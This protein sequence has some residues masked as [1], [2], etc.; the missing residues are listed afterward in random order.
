MT[1]GWSRVWSADYLVDAF[2]GLHGLKIHKC[3]KLMWFAA[4]K[5]STVFLRHL[6]EP[7]P[8]FTAVRWG[9]NTHSVLLGCLFVYLSILACL[10]DSH[11]TVV[12]RIE[13]HT[14]QSETWR[15]L[16]VKM[17]F[18]KSAHLTPFELV[19]LVCDNNNVIIFCQT[20]D[21]KTV[22]SVIR[23]L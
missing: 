6:D 17:F 9:M 20:Q 19:H 8:Y 18:K 12:V 15:L 2:A 5:R 21:K 10:L 23:S 22:V 7:P 14:C 1:S 3:I 11:I 4:L 13:T 16:W